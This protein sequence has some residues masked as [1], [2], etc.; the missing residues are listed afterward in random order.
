[1]GVVARFAVLCTAAA[2]DDVDRVTT[3]T[4]YVRL[5]RGLAGHGHDQAPVDLRI[6]VAKAPL[7]EAGAMT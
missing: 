4:A 2:A 6:D 1:V 3:W 5:V 7:I